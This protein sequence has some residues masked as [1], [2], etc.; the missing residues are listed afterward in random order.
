LKS[1]R[2]RDYW[3]D[4]G[5]DVRK[6]YL[7]EIGWKGVGWILVAQN[8]NQWQIIVTTVMNLRVP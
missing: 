8:T 4:L 5:V 7:K 2:E 6:K 1:L 3:E